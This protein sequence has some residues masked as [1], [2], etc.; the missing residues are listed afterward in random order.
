MWCSFA[1]AVGGSWASAGNQVE[2]VTL[3]VAEGR[4]A[5]AALLD[6]ANPSGSEAEQPF[7]LGVEFRGDQIEM[8]PI[9]YRLRLGHLVESQPRPL[10]AIVIDQNNCVFP[11][12]AVTHLAPKDSCP[13]LVQG[14]CIDA[15]YG[16]SKE[17]I[18]HDGL[19]YL[20]NPCSSSYAI[21][22]VQMPDVRPSG[23][24]RAA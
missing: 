14:S 7:D 3:D 5:G 1:I 9:L 15:I 2:F 12:G 11:R 23:L 22:G 21:R 10:R 8:Q 17:G 19:S 20:V 18:A 16:H 24:W 4:P 6:V 13:E